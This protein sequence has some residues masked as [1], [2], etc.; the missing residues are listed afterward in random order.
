MQF[1][2]VAT[3]GREATTVDSK[4]TNLNHYKLLN[5]YIRTLL[6][7]RQNNDNNSNNKTQHTK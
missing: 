1:S 2:K 5:V 3:R 6:A 4:E 7:S